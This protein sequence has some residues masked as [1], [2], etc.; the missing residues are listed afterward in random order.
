MAASAEAE[1]QELFSLDNALTGLSLTPDSRLESTLASLLPKLIVG[2]SRAPS[3][4]VSHKIVSELLPSLNR[5]L[6][7][8]RSLS[9]PLLSLADLFASGSLGS[10][11]SLARNLCAVYIE[12]A[13]D[14]SESHSLSHCAHTLLTNISNQP[15]EHRDI[16]LR[17][18]CLALPHCDSPLS[19]T[20]EDW[21][22]LLR[23]A[24]VLV[25]MRPGS[26]DPPPGLIRDDAKRVL[27][28]SQEVISDPSLKAMKLALLKH[29]SQSDVL[30]NADCLPL[31]LLASAHATEDNVN[32]RADEALKRIAGSSSSAS[33]VAEDERVCECLFD[34]FAGKSHAQSTPLP[35]LR[36]KTVQLLSKSR[37]AA[38]KVSRALELISEGLF[39]DS[40]S[41]A[42][43]HRTM[44][45]VA[46][47]TRHAE[48]ESLLPVARNLYSQLD[49][50]R[51]SSDKSSAQRC[52]ALDACA[53]LVA[54]IP[55]TINGSVSPMASILELLRSGSDDNIMASAREAIPIFAA[56]YSADRGTPTG[57]VM[58]LESL[59]LTH[60]QSDPEA[61]RF[62]CVQIINK[63]FT[64]T[65][66]ASSLGLYVCLL[67]VG[68]ETQA[69]RDQSEKT[70]QRVAPS[71]SLEAVL[72][73]LFTKHPELVSG[74]FTS[75][76]DTVLQSILSFSKQSA[77]REHLHCFPENF[78]S[79][80][81]AL[82]QAQRVSSSVHRAALTLLL[83][84]CER[85]ESSAAKHFLFALKESM[86]LPLLRNADSE[87]RK[88]MGMLLAVI[89]KHSEGAE[90]LLQHLM[91]N[92]QSSSESLE[93]REGAIE[94]AYRIARE[95]RCSKADE[96]VL[97][98]DNLLKS[99][100]RL[101]EIT[102]TA[103]GQCG[104]VTPIPHEVLK[105]IISYFDAGQSE[106]ERKASAIAAGLVAKGALE[107]E[108][109][110]LIVEEHLL[111]ALDIKSDD[112]AL[113]VAS[114][115]A[116][117]LA[118]HDVNLIQLTVRSATSALTSDRPNVRRTGAAVAH[119]VMARMKEDAIS[120]EAAGA[121]D[122]LPNLQREL[123]R[124]Q[125]GSS[126]SALAKEE[127]EAATVFAYA[128][129]TS[130]STKQRLA[131]LLEENLAASDGKARELLIV[132]N[133]CQK[134]EL[135]FELCDLSRK[136]RAAAS[137]L[138]SRCEDGTFKTGESS[139]TANNVLNM[140]PS[141]A[142]QLY[143]MSFDPDPE[144]RDAAERIFLA[145]TGDHGG[146]YVKA[147]CLQKA[148]DHCV[149]EC[150]SNSP[151]HRTGGASGLAQ[152][153]PDLGWDPERFQAFWRCCFR[154]MDDVSSAARSAGNELVASLSNATFKFCAPSEANNHEAKDATAAFVSVL[155]QHGLQSGTSAS[156]IPALALGVLARLMKRA[157]MGSLS[158]EQAVLVVPRLLESVGELENPKASQT[159]AIA[160][161]ENRTGNAESVAHNRVSAASRSPLLEAVE[162]AIKQ[163]GK[164]GAQ[165]LVPHVRKLIREGSVATRAA[166]AQASKLMKQQ[167][168]LDSDSAFALAQEL[169]D[170]T[171]REESRSGKRS[172][173][174]AL[175]YVGRGVESERLQQLI[176]RIR[177]WIDESGH[178]NALSSAAL[179]FKELGKAELLTDSVQ[180][181]VPC[182][183]LLA[184]EGNEWEDVMSAI[185]PSHR[186]ALRLYVHEV[187]ERIT[188]ELQESKSW[189]R[190]R[191]AVQL[192]K[193]ILQEGTWAAQSATEL[194]SAISKELPRAR[195]AGRDEMAT[196]LALNVDVCAS[197]ERYDVDYATA[198]DSLLSAI[199]KRKE[200]LFSSALSALCNS[201]ES[202]TNSNLL[203]PAQ[204]FSID[205]VISCLT[206]YALSSDDHVDNVVATLKCFVLLMPFVSLDAT[207]LMCG[208][209]QA[210]LN[211][212][213][214]RSDSRAIVKRS[215]GFVK[216]LVTHAT[217]DCSKWQE[218]RETLSHG[219]AIEGEGANENDASG[220][221]A[222]LRKVLT[223][224]TVQNAHEEVKN[225]CE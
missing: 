77:K 5:R 15:A 147:R 38:N 96:L 29:A 149:E 110:R 222:C 140:S 164:D 194:I 34:T 190:K 129:A 50:I 12:R 168:G 193:R 189:E 171:L 69:I 116:N 62:A 199:K 83:D 161:S 67:L 217:S 198:I 33:A 121:D 163:A 39:G 196:V 132:A 87:T 3:P 182:S 2:V 224:E 176:L 114:A 146:R 46:W 207:H 32:S 43:Q 133:G 173:A 180:E 204:L 174:S 153:I 167:D 172:L 93:G 36:V 119:A 99:E 219:L 63:A 28:R 17:V 211:I 134:R 49:Q 40:S 128:S 192:A 154:I 70:L 79:F 100:Q 94:A 117:A 160:T 215:I 52:R 184:N 53:Q 47:F 75:V 81:K 108:K 44:E 202:I 78:L 86:V 159:Q 85:D 88:A 186:S 138:P 65:M 48:Y 142:P 113:T 115:C 82:L 218:I 60:F 151:R 24:E 214:K 109:A 98:L 155:V 139:T 19:L 118:R 148:C 150:L 27:W 59:V 91:T 170:A 105:H 212:V 178:D 68:D 127:A 177:S 25:Q 130:E 80:L 126:D 141:P 188:H 203:N 162:E 123:M 183:L 84:W 210:V 92:M 111:K 21:L 8:N 143:R 41:P 213:S 137:V 18:S 22:T 158:A 9:L 71:S 197:A 58:E 169:V 101:R 136:P 51:Q 23:F 181:V 13:A 35:T 76:S 72:E 16:L 37:T 185:S 102:L 106:A 122:L 56:A 124:M 225:I 157:P 97:L 26:S 61:V 95:T 54:R 191:S 205:N 145:L 195:Y 175:E 20:R 14:R 206:S 200:D 103:L 144:T 31:Y 11:K 216:A 131:S 107:S 42:L 7:A 201:I 152:L 125:S 156:E 165:Q 6:D 89:S 64:G 104:E 74:R 4:R 55:E 209:L 220:M 120:P 90:E 179:L 30:S 73:L 112:L 45:F 221:H 166:A 57:V 208:M 66:R 187:T 1:Q 10:G 135:W 223:V